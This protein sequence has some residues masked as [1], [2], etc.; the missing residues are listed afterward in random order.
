MYKFLLL[1]QVI[2]GIHIAER[3]VLCIEIQIDR[4]DSSNLVLVNIF[5]DAVQTTTNNLS[6]V[7]SSTAE[8]NEPA[9][10]SMVQ[11]GPAFCSSFF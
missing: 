4:D 11:S 2:W 1:S 10:L 8:P 6:L 3:E 5:N 9:R 7:L